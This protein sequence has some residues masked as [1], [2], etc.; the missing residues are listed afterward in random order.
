MRD[1]G[2]TDA[3]SLYNTTESE[4]RLRRPLL[5]LGSQSL[6]I[7]SL[8]IER[9]FVVGLL[10]HRLGV[11]QFERWSLIVATITM[12]TMVDLGTQTTFSN[13]MSRAAHRGDIFEAGEIFRQSNTIFAVLATIVMGATIM[14]ALSAGV[15][16]WLGFQPLLNGKEQIVALALGAAV[17]LKLATTNFTGV[18]RANLAFARGT[19]ISS[20]NEIFRIGCG[21]AALLLFGSMAALA[22]AMLAATALSIALIVPLDIRRRFPGFAW[23]WRRPR[24]LTTHRSLQESLL[25][26]ST[27]LPSV[28]LTQVPVMLIGTRAAQGVLASY[29][30]LRTIAN[31]VR[32]LS[33]RVTTIL[34]MELGRLETQSRT[35]ELQAAYSQL[36]IIVAVSFGIAG[37]MLWTWGGLLIHIWAGPT[38][39]YDPLLLAIMLL[40]LMIIPGTQINIQLL[41]YGHRPGSFAAAVIAQTAGA[42]LLAFLLPI[43]SIAL[44]LSVALSAAEILLMAP[45]IA[46]A[47][48]RMI[49]SIANRVALPNIASVAAASL[50]TYAI[51]VPLQSRWPG[52]FGLLLSGVVVGLLTTPLLLWLAR[53]LA[54]TI[55]AGAV[56]DPIEYAA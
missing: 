16:S 28:V 15:Q 36:S 43:N 25:F 42:A 40:P 9:L 10:V 56:A 48:R 50:L 24:R 35:A 27:Y 2:A 4:V 55:R 33:Q 12:L 20:L 1:A 13:R 51:A 34:G 8:L 17:T 41:T 29:V 49:G 31:V 54:R 38:V 18:Y 3:K 11:G 7:L 21:I 30:L 26:A 46:V 37:M 23:A 19:L 53:R 14:F 44:R 39:H 47:T 5:D 6:T 52:L 22:L 45:I 32:M